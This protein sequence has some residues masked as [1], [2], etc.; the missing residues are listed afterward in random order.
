MDEEATTSPIL[1]K[2]R[3][4]IEHTLIKKCLFD[5][6]RQG[7]LS[8]VLL[9]LEQMAELCAAT[10]KHKYMRLVIDFK[11]QV[12][13]MPLS[14]LVFLFDATFTDMGSH[15]V[16]NDELTEIIHSHYERLVA[17]EP[18]TRETLTPKRDTIAPS[19]AAPAHQFAYLKQLQAAGELHSHTLLLLSAVSL[20]QSC[21]FWAGGD[22]LSLQYCPRLCLV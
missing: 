15:F 20:S 10:G 11:V 13:T 8:H 2:L 6:M 9:L 7:M 22:S 12:A 17:L 16:P 4:L 5:S 19:A 3:D 14:D 18:G 1:A 21:L